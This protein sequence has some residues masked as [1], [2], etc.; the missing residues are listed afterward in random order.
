MRARSLRACAL[1]L[2]VSV[3]FVFGASTASAQRKGEYLTGSELDLVRENQIIDV[4]AE[5]FLKVADRRLVALTEPAGPTGDSRSRKYGPLP[6]GSPVE[7]LD[8]YRR[9]VEE[10][11]DKLDDEFERTGMTDTLK[12]ALES[13]V[14]EMDRQLA[15]LAQIKT[16]STDPAY[17][18][19]HRRAVEGAT[20][21]RDGA[22]DALEPAP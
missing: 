4:R 8:D 12:K 1:T 17:A 15:V 5:I 21:L 19:F 6:S 9:T 20:Q 10:L 13:S 2:L 3:L 11:M 7:L 22:R 16:K 14:S 18:S